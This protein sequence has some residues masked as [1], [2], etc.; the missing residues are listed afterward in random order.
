[1]EAARFVEES[2]S[3]WKETQHK[4]NEAGSHNQLGLIH[5]LLRN[6]DKAE[7]HAHRAREILENLDLKDAW[8]SYAILAQIARARGDE[9]QAATWETKR[10]DLL[11]ELRRR[12]GGPALPSDL[13]E[14]LQSLI[15]ACVQTGFAEDHPITPIDPQIEEALAQVAKAPPPLDTLAP[16]LKALTQ[17]K[18]PPIPATLPPEVRDLLTQIHQAV[19]AG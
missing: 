8:K 1:M 10:D 5:V 4:P 7:E 13:L 15:L 17:G 9:A 19:Q 14:A 11:T 6:F 16:H 12:A 3:V 18:L 2:L